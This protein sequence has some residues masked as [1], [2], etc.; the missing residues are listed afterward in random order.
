MELYTV[1]TEVVSFI[2]RERVRFNIAVFHW[3]IVEECA[4]FVINYVAKHNFFPN[5]YEE[6][7]HRYFTPGLTPPEKAQLIG[8]VEYALGLNQQTRGYYDV[9]T[10]HFINWATLMWCW[11]EEGA[12]YLAWYSKTLETPPEIRQYP[13]NNMAQLPMVINRPGFV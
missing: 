11:S 4:K 12:T 9:D 2:N 10:I 3:R 7:S 13:R 8:P 1:P 5:N 6:A